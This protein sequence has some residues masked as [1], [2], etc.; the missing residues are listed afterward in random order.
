[1]ATATVSSNA[2]I[3]LNN[4]TGGRSYTGDGESGVFLWGAGLETGSEPTS[5]IKAEASTVTRAPDVVTLEGQGF[6]EIW[7]PDEGTILVEFD[8]PAEG[9]RV[10]SINNGTASSRI[11]LLVTPARQPQ[12]IV[13]DAGTPQVALTGAALVSAECVKMAAAIAA[14][15]FALSVNGASVIIDNSGSMPPLD[16]LHVGSSLVG[17]YLGGHVRRLLYFPRRLTNAE[18]QALST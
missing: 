18:L 2:Y 8:C 17:A 11:D 12:I 4:A 3:E 5:Y 1:M 7:N 6:S 15:D 9:G 14:G 16:R 13:L 10:L